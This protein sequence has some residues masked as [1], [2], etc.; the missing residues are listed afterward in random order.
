MSQDQG[1]VGQRLTLYDGSEVVVRAAPLFAADDLGPRI[2]AWFEELAAAGPVDPAAAFDPTALPVSRPA[3]VAFILT[4]S[5]PERGI[6]LTWCRAHLFTPDFEPIITAWIQEN[7]FTPV[8]VAV[9]RAAEG[10]GDLV[11]VFA[12]LRAS[13]QAAG[14]LGPGEVAS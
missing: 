4:T 14:G 6:D 10:L 3:L 8:L 12:W 1:S 2:L 9:R 7:N 13:A 5:D 11:K